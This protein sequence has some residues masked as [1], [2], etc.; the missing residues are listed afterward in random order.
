MKNVRLLQAILGFVPRASVFFAGSLALAALIIPAGA[1]AQDANPQKDN[2]APEKTFDVHESY[3]VGGHIADINGSGAM[4]DTMVNLKSGPRILNSTFEAHALPG[5]KHAPFDT[6]FEGS[7]GY[8]GDPN[9]MTTLRMS[10]GKLYDFSAMFRR[11]RQYFDYNLFGNPLVPAGL[12]SNG[13]TFP[14]VQ[15]AP[16]LFNTVRRMLDLNVTI[17]PISKVSFRA[18]YLKNT[19]EGPSYSSIH[20]GG[21]ALLNQYWRNNTETWLAGVDWK[22]V[23]GTTFTYEEHLNHYKGDTTWSLAGANLVLPTGQPVSLGFDNVAVVGSV[24]AT[25]GCNVAAGKASILGSGPAGF[26]ANPC[27]NGY[28]KYTRAAPTRTLFPTEEFRLQSS[29][30]KNVQITGRIMYTGANMNMPA[31][32][33]YFNGLESRVVTPVV[34]VPPGPAP[35]AWCTKATAAGVTT[36][37]DCHSVSAITGV[38]KAQRINV[39]AD[40]GIVWQITNSFSISEQYDFDNFRQPSILNQ[41]ELDGYSTSMGNAPAISITAPALVASNFLGQKIE[42]NR[43]TGSWEAASWIQLSLG[44]GLRARTLTVGGFEP[45]T[46]SD[47]INENSGLFGLVLRP[48][49]AWRVNATVENIWADAAYVQT[50][51]R[52]SQ[53]YQ[54][55]TTYKAKG[56]ATFTGAFNDLERRDNITLVNYQAHSRAGSVGASL[57]PSEHFGLDMNYGYLDVF[58]RSTNCFFVPTGSQPSD[59]VPMPGGATAPA[60]GNVNVYSATTGTVSNPGFYGTSYFDAPTHYASAAVVLTPVKRLQTV[61]GYRVTAT[62]GRTEQLNPTAVPGTLQSKYQMPFGSLSWKLSKGWGFKGDWNYYGYGEM[63]GLVGPTAPRNFHGNIG[64]LAV[65]YEY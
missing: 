32:N 49:H 4:Y 2:N 21:D 37:N 15:D 22:P 54:V 34:K 28:V 25:S 13:Y 50:D 18:G 23:R 9:N 65:H 12:V 42:S 19:N 24:S 5:A 62:D 64:T 47:K 3:D 7:S 35:T 30:L 51:P 36:Y 16:H 38:G 10:K 59:A 11:D 60:C 44:Y 26:V 52:Q 20:V 33:E 55:R 43:I 27:V 39:T 45:T 29:S 40:F 57:N 41:A 17:L 58:S 61:A 63:S 56:W 8:G 31:Y 6:L 14:Q 48:T 1:G 53:H 46:Y